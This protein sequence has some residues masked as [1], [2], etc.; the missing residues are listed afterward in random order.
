MTHSS[1]ASSSFEELGTLRHRPSVGK[2]VSTG[3]PG[4]WKLREE[5]EG[6]KDCTLSS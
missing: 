3:I 6:N 5:D 1:G 4:N 2:Q